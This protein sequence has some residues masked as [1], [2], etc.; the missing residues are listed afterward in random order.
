[1]ANTRNAYGSLLNTVVGLAQATGEGIDLV[2]KGMQSA[3]M[4]MDAHLRDKELR[5]KAE[6][7]DKSKEILETTALSTVERQLEIRKWIEANP[8]ME[9]AYNDTLAEIKKFVSGNQT[10]AAA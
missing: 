8:A 5:L 7:Y 6:S 1:M 4:S 10:A 2:S 9:D 3:T